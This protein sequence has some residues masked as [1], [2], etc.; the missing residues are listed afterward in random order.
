MTAHRELTH[1][2]TTLSLTEWA[3]QIGVAPNTLRQRLHAGQTVPQAL[4]FEP[5][6][7]AVRRAVELD[8]I[9]DSLSGH[10]RRNG[11]PYSRVYQRVRAGWPVT[12]AFAD[13]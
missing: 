7:A 1:A 10:C 6:P 8:G 3:E 11:V 5:T 4:G 13:V 2:G 9:V 12:A